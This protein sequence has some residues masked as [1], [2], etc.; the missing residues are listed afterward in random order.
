MVVWSSSKIFLAPSPYRVS[1]PS[2]SLPLHTPPQSVSDFYTNFSSVIP[3]YFKLWRKMKAAKQKR[4]A[5]NFCDKEQ[6]LVKREKRAANNGGTRKEQGRKQKSNN[7]KSCLKKW[8]SEWSKLC[9]PV[10]LL[11]RSWWGRKPKRGTEGR[12]SSWRGSERVR[13]RK[14]CQQKTIIM[15][16]VDSS[17]KLILFVFFTF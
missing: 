10:I 12:Y 14:I 1:Y 16:K 17:L 6:K 2:T 4:V 15:W 3:C 13:E 5:P 8:H 11:N 9:R 7:V